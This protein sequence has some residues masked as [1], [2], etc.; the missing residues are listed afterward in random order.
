MSDRD[1]EAEMKKIDKQMERVSDEA[2]F[3]SAVR[4]SSPARPATEPVSASDGRSWPIRD[5]TAAVD[6]RRPGR[7][8]GTASTAG[9]PAALARNRRRSP[10]R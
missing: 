2:I 5:R 10:S 3:P 6:R 1:W 7:S 9:P 8:R 4:T